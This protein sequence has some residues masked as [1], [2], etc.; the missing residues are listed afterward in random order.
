V[1]RVA[2]AVAL[3]CLTAY[4]IS[5]NLGNFGVQPPFRFPSGLNFIGWGLHIDQS[6]AMF[7][8]HPPKQHWW[9]VIWA[10]KVNGETFE[11]FRNRGIFTW[12]GNVPYSLE[13]PSPYHESFKNHRWFKYFENGFNAKNSDLRLYFG[14]WV[15]RNY[16]AEHHDEERLYHFKVNLVIEDQ[17]PEGPRENRRTEELWEH[18]CYEKKEKEKAE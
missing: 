5:W 3:V 13:K 8:P 4:V 14:K 10:E 7:S 6:W 9:Y 12:E 15:C 16:N 18:I 11:L 1:T 17:T 2:G